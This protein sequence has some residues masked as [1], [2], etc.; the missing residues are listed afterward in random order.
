MDLDKTT[1]IIDLCAS[2]L[3]NGDHSI[4]TQLSSPDASLADTLFE[5]FP[6]H[7]H[8][9]YI[10]PWFPISDTDD[11]RHSL[12]ANVPRRIESILKYSSL[13]SFLCIFQLIN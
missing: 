12:L 13:N 11:Q 2:T 1:E 4:V 9:L 6:N 3:D 10:L 8:R 7:Y 5:R